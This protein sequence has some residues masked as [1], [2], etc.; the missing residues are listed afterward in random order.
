MSKL[1]DDGASKTALEAPDKPQ[2]NKPVTPAAKAATLAEVIENV[3][4]ARVT[5]R[6]FKNSDGQVLKKVKTVVPD[7]LVIGLM[8]FKGWTLKDEIPASEFDKAWKAFRAKKLGENF[9]K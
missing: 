3:G 4:L 2:K 7:A 9:G 8:H 5:V 6:E 1:K